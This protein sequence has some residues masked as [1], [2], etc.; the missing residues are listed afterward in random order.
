MDDTEAMEEDVLLGETTAAVVGILAKKPSKQT[1]CDQ[2]RRRRGTGTGPAGTVVTTPVTG[3][4]TAVTTSATGTGPTGVSQAQAPA[5]NA[6]PRL[7]PVGP[8]PVAE[9]VNL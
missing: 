1:S 4:G 9:V 7:T 8:V 5:R 2:H 3:T 6:V